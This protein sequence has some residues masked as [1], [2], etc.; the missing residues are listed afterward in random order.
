M[1]ERTGSFVFAWS[2]AFGLVSVL[3]VCLGLYHSLF[4]R[5]QRLIVREV[6]VRCP[7]S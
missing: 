3:L 4:C 2:V 5:V 1:Q 6:Q 7:V